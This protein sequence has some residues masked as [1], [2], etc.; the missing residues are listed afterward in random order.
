M[1]ARREVGQTAETLYVIL[2][3]Q[4]FASTAIA[5]TSRLNS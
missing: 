1:L 3:K 2:I 4:L 5:S